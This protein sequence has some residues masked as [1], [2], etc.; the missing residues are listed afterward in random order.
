MR[1]GLAAAL[2][3]VA[4]LGVVGGVTGAIPPSRESDDDVSLTDRDR[5][6]LAAAQ[7][8]RD[9]KNYKRLRDE[10]RVADG[11]R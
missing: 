9:R 4:A 1:K 6:A 5:Q 7:A 2:P 8:K 11:K 3:L 10:R